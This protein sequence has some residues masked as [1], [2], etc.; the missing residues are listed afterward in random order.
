M[1]KFK[2]SKLKIS[3]KEHPNLYK[4]PKRSTKVKSKNGKMTDDFLKN[5]KPGKEDFKR[6]LNLIKNRKEKEKFCDLI[7]HYAKINNCEEYWIL[8]CLEK[9]SYNLYD[10]FI[11]K[12]SK[13]KWMTYENMKL[14]N[15]PVFNGSEKLRKKI[16]I[17]FY[18]LPLFNISKET[19]TNYL[20]IKG[21]IPAYGAIIYN[22][23]D[24]CILLTRNMNSNVWNFPKGKIDNINEKKLDCVFRELHEEI[25]QNFYNL[26]QNKK[27]KLPCKFP[28][29]ISNKYNQT[30]EY[31]VFITETWDFGEPLIKNEIADMCFLKINLKTKQ[32]ESMTFPYT[33]NPPSRPTTITELLSFNHVRFDVI[34]KIIDC[35][36]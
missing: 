28:I 7:I 3:F 23:N 34:K 18:F 8:Y 6:I 11:K 25:G 10:V 20:D 14:K 27:I 15:I 5:D 2:R 12:Y 30:F 9:Y 35:V 33:I 16:P 1:N 31:F 17:L 24:Q 32:F 13:I 19:I 21:K 29:S 36:S 22:K 4:K 26:Y